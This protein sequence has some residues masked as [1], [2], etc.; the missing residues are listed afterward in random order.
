VSEAFCVKRG[1]AVIAFAL[2][3]CAS[4][5]PPGANVAPLAAPDTPFTIA[6]RLS[7]RH[8]DAGVAG[9]FSWRHEP[10]HDAIELSS[11]LGQTL[12]RLDGGPAA[13]TAQLSDGKTRSAPTWRALTERAF[14][15]T[16]PID[17]LAS[18]IRAL[19]RPGARFTV[20]RDPSGRVA[21]LRQDGW[22]IAYAYADDRAQKPFRVTL[23]YPGPEPIEVRVV[24][25]RR[26]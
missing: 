26:E 7:A 12:A 20:E 8:A 18:W 11:P 17:G 2:G 5:P 23:S 21:Q 15:V 10:G 13:V 14:G 9:S 6:G 3:A 4:L 1:L 24:V 19:P 25:D 22:D 16:I